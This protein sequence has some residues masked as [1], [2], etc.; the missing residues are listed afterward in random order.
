MRMLGR[1]S[2]FS[3]VPR[4]LITAA[5]VSSL[6]ASTANA[7]PAPPGSRF[8]AVSPCRVLDTRLPTGP[9]GGDRKS[10]RLNSSHG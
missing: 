1:H 9:Q 3:I 6:A 8:F 7:G 5:A 10:T 4:L 2:I